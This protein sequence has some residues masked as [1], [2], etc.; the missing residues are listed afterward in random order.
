LVVEVV[1]VAQAGT[2]VQ[3]AQVVQAH[4]LVVLVQQVQLLQV[5]VLVEQ[6]LLATA[7][8]QA[9]GA[10]AVLWVQRVALVVAV[11]TQ[12]QQVA[13]TQL[14]AEIFH[15]LLLAVST[16]LLDNTFPLGIHSSVDAINHVSRLVLWLTTRSPN[17]VVRSSPRCKAA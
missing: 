16:A 9:R 7:R 13:T 15:G 14:A 8:L 4:M 5:Q 17:Y 3:V 10:Q 12:V 2:Q 1:E 11:A 6:V